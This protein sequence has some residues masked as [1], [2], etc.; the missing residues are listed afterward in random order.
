MVK[1]P[2]EGTQRIIPYLYYADAPAAIDFL[3]RAF[4]F[5]E[6]FRMPDAAGAVMHAELSLAD[7]IVMLATAPAERGCTSPRDLPALHSSVGIYVDDVDAHHA[8]AKAAGAHIRDE[9]TDQFYGDRTYSATD[10]EGHHWHF[11]THFRDVPL[12]EMLG[13]R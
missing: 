12:E 4:G 6:R 1:N 9:P 11:L 8:Q 3:C 7:N 13:P 5:T 10:P 2:P